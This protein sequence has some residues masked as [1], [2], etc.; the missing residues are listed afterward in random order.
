M[1]KCA[2]THASASFRALRYSLPGSNPK[3]GCLCLNGTPFIN[4]G[5]FLRAMKKL[6]NYKRKSY[7]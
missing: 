1:T 6:E 3:R 2:P 4:A 7:D 5:S